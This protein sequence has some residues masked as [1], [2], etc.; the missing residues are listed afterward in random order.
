[1]SLSLTSSVNKATKSIK[2]FDC[3][4]QN[5]SAIPIS[6]I[7]KG[8]FFHKKEIST[9][10]PNDYYTKLQT[11]FELKKRN[12]V[13]KSMLFSLEN[14][15]NGDKERIKTSF[16]Y[17]KNKKFCGCDCNDSGT[18]GEVFGENSNNF[19]RSCGNNGRKG[20]KNYFGGA[21]NMENSMKNKRRGE[22]V[23]GFKGV[24]GYNG[25]NNSKNMNL[26]HISCETKE[27]SK[28]K[29]LKLL[30]EKNV[31]YKF[32]LRQ[33]K[34]L[35]QQ[36]KNLKE[37]LNAIIRENNEY[38]KY[39]NLFKR[40][41]ELK[42]K[43]MNMVY[44]LN[45]FLSIL[46]CPNSI[47]DFSPKEPDDFSYSENQ[48]Q[49]T[50]PKQE[51]NNSISDLNSVNSF[52]IYNNNSI[53]NE[54]ESNV[55]VGLKPKSKKKVAKFSSAKKD[56]NDSDRVKDGNFAGQSNRKL[57][58]K[59]NV[60]KN[61]QQV[62]ERS[63]Y[64]N[65]QNYESNNVYLNLNKNNDE[66]IEINLEKFANKVNIGINNTSQKLIKN[67][68]N[69]SSYVTLHKVNN[70][71]NSKNSKKKMGPLQKNSFINRDFLEKLN[72]NIYNNNMRNIINSNNNNIQKN[73]KVKNKIPYNRIKNK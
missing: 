11:N 4:L 52:K 19:T 48:V 24:Q 49:F 33:N 20:Y 27:K 37:K 8:H 38:I 29:A 65:V 26:S 43:I 32:V 54:S 70:S 71:N 12:D 25:E 55:S 68:K 17:D 21:E 18:E 64:L 60:S 72:N 28:E 57:Y 56:I 69:K 50:E 73:V 15:D 46:N 23:K 42:T 1:M 62:D 39:V 5:L 14:E 45:K 58:H 9:I 35:L 2:N 7:K 34:R 22:V 40:K 41:D 61:K 6:N 16:A 47:S 51:Q 31:Y 67:N 63:N 36:N 13:L 53:T 44:S 66:D 10:I 59:R 3:F 30:L